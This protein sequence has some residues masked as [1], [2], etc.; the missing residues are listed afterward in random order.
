MIKSRRKRWAGHVACRGL[1][2]MHKGFWWESQNE[3]DYFEDIA[4]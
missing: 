1:R 4:V 2:G 3:R